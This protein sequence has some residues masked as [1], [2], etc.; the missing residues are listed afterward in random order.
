[1][2]YIYILVARVRSHEVS[3]GAIAANAPALVPT[4]PA[5]TSPSAV[6]T[7]LIRT[8]SRARMTT[9]EISRATTSYFLH[10]TI[11]RTTMR[12]TSYSSH[13]T[14]TPTTPM[15]P[16]RVPVMGSATASVTRTTTAMRAVSQVRYTASMLRFP[17]FRTIM[18]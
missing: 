1:M 10:R 4:T 13:P 5:A 14:T 18:V 12:T 7:A 15:H 16:S 3:T 2:I 6:S 8:A 11:P 17:C 9:A